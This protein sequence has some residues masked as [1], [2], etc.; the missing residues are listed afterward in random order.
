[1]IGRLMLLVGVGTFRDAE[2]LAS[3]VRRGDAESGKCES[4]GF[5]FKPHK[6]ST[7]EYRAE[8]RAGSVARRGPD[9]AAFRGAWIDP[10]PSLPGRGS[11]H[12]LP[13]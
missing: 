12:L 2:P 6:R 5:L 9:S 4:P 1:M 8:Y 13:I 3:A 10:K 7:S 11:L